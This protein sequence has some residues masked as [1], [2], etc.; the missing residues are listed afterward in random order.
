MTDTKSSG[1][2]FSD[3]LTDAEISRP[4]AIDAIARKPIATASSAIGTDLMKT[5][6]AGILRPAS[7]PTT[8]TAAC[9]ALMT[10]SIATLDQR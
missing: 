4:S 9:S 8:I 3:V 7:P 10:P 1:R 2:L 5:P 6:W